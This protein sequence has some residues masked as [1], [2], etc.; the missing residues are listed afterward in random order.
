[1][2]LKGEAL[3]FGNGPNRLRRLGILAKLV[4]TRY[5][6]IFILIYLS[7]SIKW[8]FSDKRLF[9]V[10]RFCFLEAGEMRF[11]CFVS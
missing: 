1:M 10:G 3:E 6:I 9:G 5:E 8:C 2:L 7:P 4:L 11:V